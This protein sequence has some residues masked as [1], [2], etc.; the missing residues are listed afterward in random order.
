MEI[1]MNSMMHQ[2][3]G[4]HNESLEEQRMLERA[5]EESKQQSADPNSDNPNTDNMSYEQL[6]QLEERMGHVSKG[7]SQ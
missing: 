6:L 4:G 3:L 5:I 7:L 1:M 2:H